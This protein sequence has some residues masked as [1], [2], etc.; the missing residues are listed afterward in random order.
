GITD[1][2]PVLTA[3][4][5]HFIIQRNLVDARHQLVSDRISLVRALGGDWPAARIAARL[6]GDQEKEKKGAE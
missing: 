6:E 1:Y 4:Q 2:L 5:Q 3:Q